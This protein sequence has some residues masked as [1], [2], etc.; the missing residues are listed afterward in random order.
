[1]GTEAASKAFASEKVFFDKFKCS[2][3]A[4]VASDKLVAKIGER[5]FP[6]V[7]AAPVI[8]GMMVFGME[9][10]QEV[11][12]AIQVEATEIVEAAKLRSGALVP[13][14]RW[15]WPFSFR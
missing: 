6:W 15:L 10:T 4:I 5:Y 2:G 11:P 8:L 13:S 1:M 9:V 3:S 7:T 14:N 12:G